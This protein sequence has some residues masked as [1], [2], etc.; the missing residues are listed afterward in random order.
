MTTA[1]DNR[2]P[3]PELAPRERAIAE[4]ALQGMRY[5]EIAEQLNVSEQ[6]VKN[7]MK[8]V[9]DKCGAWSRVELAARFRCA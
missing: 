3:L 1:I 7:C 4:L 5:R 9:L 6:T 2:H 8:K